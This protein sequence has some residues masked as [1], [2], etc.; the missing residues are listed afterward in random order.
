MTYASVG[1]QEVRIG[2]GS[3]YLSRYVRQY[4]FYMYHG[5]LLGR[6]HVSTHENIYCTIDDTQYR[7]E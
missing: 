7:F 3:V 2:D 4:V 1:G 6:P 5:G